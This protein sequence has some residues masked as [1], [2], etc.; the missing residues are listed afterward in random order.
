LSCEQALV[1]YQAAASVDAHSVLVLAPH[2]DDEIFGCGGAIAQHVA[3]GSA[4]HVVVLTA[5]D[6]GGSAAVRADESRAAAGVLGCA[7]PE[8]WGQPDRHLAAS[9]DLTQRLVTC[10]EARSVDL[11]YVPSPQE[12][13]PDHR[14]AWALVCAAAAQLQQPVRVAC[15]EVGNPL[16]RPNLLLDITP[17]MEAKRAAMACFAS[18]NAHQDYA[19][20][21]EG[22]SRYRSYTLPRT[23]RAAEAFCV[24]LSTDLARPLGIDGAVAEATTWGWL[25]DPATTSRW[26]APAKVSVVVRS[27]GGPLLHEALD[28]VARQTWPHIEVVV[29]A[30]GTTHPPLPARCGPFP[31]RLV[32]QGPLTPS[33]AANAGLENACGDYVLILDD[34]DWLL[35]S[36]V[37]RLA[38][39]LQ[40]QRLW[41]AAYAGVAMVDAESR[42]IGQTI[43]LPFD[44]M[45]QRSGNLTPI[46]AVLFER[47]LFDEGCRFDE[48]LDRYEN[49]DFWLQ[50]VSRTAMAHVPG[51]SAAYRIGTSAGVLK[52]ASVMSASTQVIYDKWAAVWS[53]GQ[54]QELMRRAWAFDE[55]AAELARTAQ[56]LTEATVQV[57]EARHASVLAQESQALLH[58]SLLALQIQHEVLAQAHRQ[59]AA[60]L[61]A[62]Q[63]RR[64]ALKGQAEELINE[65]AAVRYRA[66]RLQVDLDAMRASISWRFTAPLRR[67]ASLAQVLRRALRR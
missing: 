33:R 35:P 25:D 62:E 45:R 50:V 22:L 18:Q 57:R 63:S 48:R 14:Q 47:A 31:L 4:V 12:V 10:I 42:P 51:V 64:V 32:Q 7:E 27:L 58:A 36:H 65:S 56:T 5:G 21:L 53:D 6:A 43:D 49:W 26:R 23:V 39:A 1:P 61:G 46:H 16:P 8:F 41:R 38:G 3:Q 55:Q 37:A 34:D 60:Q 19:E 9:A 24:L 44:P 59:Q 54:K 15:Y 30:A 11:L 40:G 2:P 20:Q 52:D 17:W 29:V 66:E 13:H 28:S 67:A